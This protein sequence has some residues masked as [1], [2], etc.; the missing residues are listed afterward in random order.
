[1]PLWVGLSTGGFS[2]VLWHDDRKTD[3]HEWSEAVRK[4]KLTAGLKALHPGRK[5]GDWKVLC[6]N[7]SFLRTPKSLKAYRRPHVTLIGIPPRSPDLN[8]VEKMRGWVRKQLRAM[9]LRDLAK[10]APVLGR[11]MYRERIKRLLAF[12]ERPTSCKELR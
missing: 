3:E 4:G 2:A 7:E 5:V 1:M 11:T 10:G 9:D 6:D 12:A 8:R